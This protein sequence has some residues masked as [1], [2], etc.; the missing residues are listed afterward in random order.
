MD[1]KNVSDEVKQNN[2]EQRHLR[3]LMKAGKFS[4]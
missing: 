3:G 2:R 1:Y 4:Y